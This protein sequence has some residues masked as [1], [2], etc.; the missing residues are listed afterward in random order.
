[1]RHSMTN[2]KKPAYLISQKCRLF[3]VGSST[4]IRTPGKTQKTVHL[5]HFH[6]NNHLFFISSKYPAVII[7]E[8]KAIIAIPK[9]DDTIVT[10]L[11]I[12]E[13]GYMSP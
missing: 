13:T 8:G 10:I 2:L 4:Q 1:M 6:L 12:F 7:P 5:S 11:P 9:T 3:Y